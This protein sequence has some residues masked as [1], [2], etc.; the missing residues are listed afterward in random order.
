MT[1]EEFLSQLD[2]NKDG[3]VN[4]DDALKLVKQNAKSALYMGLFVGFLAG[5][6][7]I[8]VVNVIF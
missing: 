6:S 8:A 5:G 2:L 1:R 3:K 4:V 7:F